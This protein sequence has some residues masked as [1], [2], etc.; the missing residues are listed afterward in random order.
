[1]NDRVP[2]T[3]DLTTAG[4]VIGHVL[5]A[6]WRPTLGGALALGMWQGAETMMPTTVG[7]VV[8]RAIEQGDESALWWGIAAVGLVTLVTT[9]GFR[10]GDRWTTRALVDGIRDLQGAVARRVLRSD[11]M[12]LGPRLTTG[13]VYRA[14]TAD[15]EAAT[16]IIELVAGGAAALVALVAPA[17]VLL[18]IEPLLGLIIIVAVPPIVFGLQLV[19]KVLQRHEAAHAS[20]S[21]R[22]VSV[23]T[24][25]VAGM[26]VVKGLWARPTATARY[27]TA[28]QSARR[29]RERLAWTTG[30]F[31]GAVA[32]LTGAL[33]ALVALVGGKFALDGRIGLGELVAVVGVTRLFVG[34]FQW[35]SGL[36][37]TVA[38]MRAGAERVAA[39]IAAPAAIATARAP[40]PER[41]RRPDRPA[42]WRSPT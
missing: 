25:L 37:G 35:V 8:G 40:R 12:V 6:Q 32:A 18:V 16:K 4:G 33:T 19:G 5:R 15:A 23:A 2:R 26:R 11:G 39:V 30:G 10:Y 34:S 14:G 3:A 13:D 28:S 24:D 20:A 41:S 31:Q 27:A 22:A 17:V 7:F 29:A 1:M 21:A 42:S 9:V 38:T 36:L